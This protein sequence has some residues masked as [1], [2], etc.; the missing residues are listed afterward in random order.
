MLGKITLMAD[1]DSSEI[2]LL[3]KKN[4]NKT[5]YNESYHCRLVLDVMNTDG[6]MTA[7]CMKA[8]ICETTFYKW[9][10]RYPVFSDCYQ[11]GK[12]Y[13]RHNWEEE[14]RY[15]KDDESF[16][17]DY[18]RLVGS[19]RYGVGRTNRVR[20]AIDPDSDPYEQYKQLVRQAG[21]EEFTA[22][23]IK[24]LMESINVGR[25]VFETF[26]L[27]E[28]MNELKEDIIRMK[29]HHEHNTGTTQETSEAG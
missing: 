9:L 28:G 12:M 1:I 3:I 27:Q 20:L 26:K 4:N 7:F 14:G 29:A 15:G 8:S 19:Y 10:N 22:S 5:V 25:G 24:Q 11:I 23:E 2:Y 21:R 16:N 17:M 13:S 6:T 18:W